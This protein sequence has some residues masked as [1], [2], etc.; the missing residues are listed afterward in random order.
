MMH[1]GAISSLV[2]EL[3]REYLEFY[4]LDYTKQI[5]VPEAGLDIKGNQRSR[6][7][8]ATDC[9]LSRTN[10]PQKPLLV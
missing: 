9:K 6:E 1:H 5:Y 10:N 2:A 7:D 4:A 8:L 3:V